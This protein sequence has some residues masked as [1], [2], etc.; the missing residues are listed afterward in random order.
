[1]PGSFAK[2]TGPSMFVPKPSNEIIAFPAVMVA[3]RSQFEP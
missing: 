2:Q 3:T 1:M